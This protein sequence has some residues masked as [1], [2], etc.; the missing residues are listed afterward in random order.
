MAR[1]L[2]L[3]ISCSKCATEIDREDP[4][5]DVPVLLRVDKHEGKIDLCKACREEFEQVLRPYLEGLDTPVKA[6]SLS[7]R[8]VPTK[9][10]VRNGKSASRILS[11]RCTQCDREIFGGLPKVRDH[12]TQ[13][14]EYTRPEAVHEVPMGKSGVFYEEQFPHLA[15]RIV[16]GA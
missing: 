8:P 2:I 11:F 6:S 15:N 14:H 4:T 13:R 7:Q 3:V 12:L 9:T 10:Q 16:R 5:Y 1:E